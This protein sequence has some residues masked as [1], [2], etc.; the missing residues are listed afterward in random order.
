MPTTTTTYSLNKPLVN[1]AT[2]QDL[3]G[4]YLNDNMDTIDTQMLLCRDWKKR[5]ITTTDSVVAGD[6]HKILLC[7]AT[8][9]A[10]T[11]TL[12]AAAT[13]GDGFELTIVKTDATASAVTIDG[14]G[15]ETIAGSATFALSGQG[16]AAT[17]VCDG[18]SNWN[19][20]G[21]KTTPS[22][23]AAASTTAA[24]IIE[25]AT[26]AEVL[27][28]ASTTLAVTP[29][30]LAALVTSS[31]AGTAVIGTVRLQWGIKTGNLS[32]GSAV[33]FGTAFSNTPY[34]VIISM[35]YVSGVGV[36]YSGWDAVTTTGFTVY[37]SYA[38]T[39]SVYWLAIGP[40]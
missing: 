30:S 7:D 19:F 6:R 23:V 38:G 18:V 27:A 40:V 24:G 8:A 34:A 13:A 25:I 17:L 14:S 3:W 26:N 9:G 39:S 31:A 33:L 15:A 21:N 36:G 2:D 32:G 10:F 35:G 16:D 1:N 37:D 22:A 29:A 5:V 28:A 11:E 4:G 12:L 20:K